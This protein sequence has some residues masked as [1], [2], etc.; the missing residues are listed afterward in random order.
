MGAER[1]TSK[2]PDAAGFTALDA[3]ERIAKGELRAT[4]YL[5]ACL[6]RIDAREDEVKAWRVFD[7]DLAMKRA[8]EADAH[9]KTGRP[10]GPLHGI[11]VGIKDIIDTADLPTENGTVLDSGR[12]PR[13]DAVL[14]A[15]LRAAGAIILGKT[16]TTELAY[17]TPRETRNPHD[18]TRTPGGSSSGSAAAVAAGMV[19]LAVGTQTAGSVIRPASFCGVVGYKPT[20]GLIPRTGVLLQAAPL[21]TIG[22]FA[23]SVDDAALIAD[24]LAGHDA[25]D[26]DSLVEAPPRLFELARSKP[27]LKP[28]FALVRQPTW[29]QAEP[30]T[31]EAFGELVD[32]LG[33]LCD[34]TPLPDIFAEA[35]AAH[36]AVMTAGFARNLRR[37]HER[38]A[39]E[40]SPQL[41]SAI[42]EGLAVTA[43][44]YL[45]ALD[46]RDVLLAGLERIF[47][48]YDAI[49]T[50]AAIGE[51]PVGLASTGLP[52]FNSLW[53]LLGLPA[54]TLP[55]MQGPNGM[56]LG[57][58]L[59]GR[60]GY[61]GRLLRT[62]RW[63]A[64][65]VVES[66]VVKS[67]AIS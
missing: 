61:D 57:V 56:P 23:R 3:R 5:A 37:Y 49:V 6:E 15:R 63:L 52:V 19:P 43:V 25:G 30:A 16:V 36:R 33:A 13:R 42:K 24:V 32:E 2:R 1:L 64:Q 45:S 66:E 9:R 4:D 28:L 65:H 39:D 48:R 18:P 22:V 21:D 38:G 12:R 59:V 47:E 7:R 67:E 27:P 31:R 26:P 62:A 46:W 58:Q 34:E 11:P 50:P 44:Q 14:V 29:D 40:L 10:I 35:A 53:T 8:D 60:R 54:V 17:S 41:L 20:F 55:L 51:A